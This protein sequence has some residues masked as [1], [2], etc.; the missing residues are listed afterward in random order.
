MQYIDINLQKIIDAKDNHIEK[1]KPLI[2]SRASNSTNTQIMDF[3]TESRIEV[4]LK[5][6]PKKLYQLQLAFLRN[7]IPNFIFKEWLQF[8]AIT[9]TKNFTPAEIRLKSIFDDVYKEVNRI[10]DYDNFCEKKIKTT[11]SH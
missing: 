4:I 6:S 2:Y 3:L 7:V 9:R 1:L 8:I 10:F 5:S 11:L